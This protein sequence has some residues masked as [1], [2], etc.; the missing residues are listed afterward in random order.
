M[1]PSDTRHPPQEPNMNAFQ[2]QRP[3][4]LSQRA[5][6]LALVLLVNAGIAAFIDGLAGAGQAA[7]EMAVAKPATTA[8]A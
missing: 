2:P 8:R 3:R 5:A 1:H 7:A 4:S 6:V